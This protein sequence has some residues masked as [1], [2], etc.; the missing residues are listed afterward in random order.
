MPA[1]R[2]STPAAA[3]LVRL[4]PGVP[5]LRSLGARSFEDLMG[6]SGELEGE[7]PAGVVSSRA[8]RT[9]LRYA[10][11]GTVHRVGERRVPPRGAGTGFVYLTRWTGGGLAERA[12]ARLTAPRSASFAAR[13]WN[14]LCHLREHGV[15]TAEPLA[16][17]EERAPLFAAR[18]FLATRELDGMFSLPEYLE[19]HPD[20]PSRRR[21]ARALGLFVS[22]I[23][24]ARVALPRLA[25][26]HV[27]VSRTV[28]GDGCAANQLQEFQ[29]RRA[30]GTALPVRLLPELALASV[31]GGR[32]VA[33]DSLELRAALLARL[34]AGLDPALRVAPRDLLRTLRHASGSRPDRA[35][36]RRLARL[37]AGGAAR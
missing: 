16:M 3:P 36:R 17:G 7:A 26:E 11:P 30:R 19:R 8:G 12:R 24:G 18:S 6:E 14:L 9:V 23:A 21:L 10:L 5:D 4:W 29:A 13:A 2:P 33:Q 34:E 22:R 31:E 25:P 28:G 1:T 37:A 20:A 35:A 27:F 32:L 15:G